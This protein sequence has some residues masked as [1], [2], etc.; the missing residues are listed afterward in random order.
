M[1]F[2]KTKNSSSSLYNSNL[3]ERTVICSYIST[4]NEQRSV[5]LAVYCTVQQCY[6]EVHCW[7]RNETDDVQIFNQSVIS[8]SSQHLLPS[9]TFNSNINYIMFFQM[10]NLKHSNSTD[11]NFFS[12]CYLCNLYKFSVKLGLLYSPI[13]STTAVFLNSCHGNNLRWCLFHQISSYMCEHWRLQR[14]LLLLYSV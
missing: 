2:N 1:L 10:F 4:S 5:S 11:W 7:Q 14:L 6:W 13:S 12:N 3:L 9:C 8:C